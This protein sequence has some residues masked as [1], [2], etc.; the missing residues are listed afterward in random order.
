MQGFITNKREGGKNVIIPV[1]NKV[2][3]KHI[4]LYQQISF[5]DQWSRGR[6]SATEMVDLGSIPGQVKPKTI[7]IDIHSFLLD[8]Q[9]L[10]GRQRVIQRPKDI[11][12]AVSWPTQLG[13]KN[14]MKLKL[15]VGVLSKLHNK[16]QHVLEKK[17][18]GIVF[19]TTLV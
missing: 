11:L 4:K 5:T 2:K 19:I 1:Q 14:V 7:Q 10:K 13:E 16:T 9:Q 15:P 8:V 6:A 12:F 18:L 17:L 3:A